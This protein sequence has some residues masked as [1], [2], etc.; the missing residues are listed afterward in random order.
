MYLTDRSQS[1]SIN[2]LLSELS[3]LAFGVPQGSVLEPILKGYPL[4]RDPVSLDISRDV[5]P[6][7]KKWRVGEESIFSQ[8]AQYRG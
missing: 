8:L 5:E 1:V 3:Q 7:V 6:A 2:G 4:S